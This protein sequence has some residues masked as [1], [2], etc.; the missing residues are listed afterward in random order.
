MVSSRLDALAP[1]GAAATAARASGG[2]EPWSGWWLSPVSSAPDRSAIAGRSKVAVREVSRRPFDSGGGGCAARAPGTARGSPWDRRALGGCVGGRAA[3]VMSAGGPEGAAP[4]PEPG[5]VVRCH[6]VLGT[7]ASA[8]PGGRRRRLVRLGSAGSGSKPE[9]QASST[10][11]GRVA[12]S[13]RL[14]GNDPW[15][16]PLIAGIIPGIASLEVAD[17][18]SRPW[19]SQRAVAAI[20]AAASG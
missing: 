4:G 5:A 6:P 9:S 16:I 15:P 8:T 20:W 10:T 13:A 2:L 18:I 12:A 1:P 19:D 14:R 3:E 7:F 11:V 17:A